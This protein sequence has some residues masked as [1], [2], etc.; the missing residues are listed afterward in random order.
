[1]EIDPK[2]YQLLAIKHGLKACINGFRLNRAYTPSRLRNAVEELS[3]KKFKGYPYKAMLE[4]VE[5]LLEEKTGG[6]GSHDRL[7]KL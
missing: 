4:T 3:G 5:K 2:I 1:M 7:E 6:T